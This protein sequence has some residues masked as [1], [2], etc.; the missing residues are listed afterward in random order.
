MT[1]LNYGWMLVFICFGFE[2]IIYF[3]VYCGWSGRVDLFGSF[4]FIFRV[5]C[6]LGVFY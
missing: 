6:E 2:V 1:G 5:V 3:F 4:G